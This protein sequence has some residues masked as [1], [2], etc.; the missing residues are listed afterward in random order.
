[1]VSVIA[2]E[3]TLTGVDAAAP[4][5]VRRGVHVY[6]PAGCDATVEAR[7]DTQLV[8]ASAP[9]AEQ[10]PG[11]RVLVR[12]EQFLAACAVQ[13]HAL[14]WI[15]TPQ[16]LSRRVVLYHDR[17]LRSRSGRPV[18]WFHTTMFDVA[19]LPPNGD[20]EPVFKMCYNH[21]T[22]PNFC[23]DV[24]GRA[25][26][27]MALH[28]YG[29]DAQA[30]GP[31]SSLDGESTYHLNESD[32]DP[33]IEWRIEDGVRQPLR[34]KHEVRIESGYVSLFCMFDPSPTGVECHAAGE[35]SEYGP[36]SRT[37]GTAAYDRYMSLLAPLDHMVETLS[38]ATALGRDDLDQ[39]P[40][41]ALY[42]Q[43]LAAQ[44]ACER[45]LHDQ[46][47]ADGHGREH[48]LAPWMLDPPR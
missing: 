30:W 13:G 2:G 24:Q 48:I 38:M 21:R 45:A 15:L 29:L 39:T 17:C 20:G 23:Y 47:V 6:L 27:R 41:W 18:S 16:Y 7:A 3:A 44:H 28:P 36:L 43:G 35:Y 34:N 19:G 46:L 40:E 9:S 37:L 5:A 1:M 12:D 31:W 22:E 11:D 10:A 42:Q 8:I 33:L 32:T 4:L 25:A 26:V 14:R